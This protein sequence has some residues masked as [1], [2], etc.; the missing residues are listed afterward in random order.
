MQP[1][2]AGRSSAPL[3][4][5][6]LLTHRRAV[7]TACPKGG[8]AVFRAPRGHREARHAGV[9]LLLPRRGMRHAATS[10]YPQTISKCERSPSGRRVDPSP[11]LS[12]HGQA[13]PR[14]LGHRPVRARAGAAAP[15]APGE[16]NAR[17]DRPLGRRSP[18]TR[19][20]IGRGYS[21]RHRNLGRA[22][23]GFG[24][25]AVREGELPLCRRAGASHAT[26]QRL[27]RSPPR[28][29]TWLAWRI[30]HRRTSLRLQAF[31]QV[32]QINGKDFADLEAVLSHNAA[33]GNRISTAEQQA[34]WFRPPPSAAT[35]GNVL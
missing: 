32:L 28:P 31:R 16:S 34:H 21:A 7:E 26:Q 15:G 1:S 22:D 12:G 11:T 17:G 18:P 33:N 13:H 3:A 20:G 6:A 2:G 4:R 9:A 8:S 14:Q 19:P 24:A 10:S 5:D 30:D 25:A 27:W 23:Q 29:E 35:Q